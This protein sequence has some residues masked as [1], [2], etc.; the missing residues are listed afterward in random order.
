MILVI[1]AFQ[2]IDFFVIVYTAIS[3]HY[4]KKENE[5]SYLSISDSVFYICGAISFFLSF[6]IIAIIKEQDRDSISIGILFFV[7]CLLCIWI[8]LIQK[9][10]RIKYNNDVLIFRNCFGVTQKY[11][12]CDIR[13]AD[14]SR[15][16][17]IFLN[18]K[19]I[20]SWDTLIINTAED[21]AI[22]IFFRQLAHKE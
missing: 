14:G 16:S 3:K 22:S 11:N 10:W 17:K 8:M 15:V 12:V 20:I 18:K 4:F 7:A 21:V 2:I 1:R 6:G 19:P 13:F 9:I 5:W